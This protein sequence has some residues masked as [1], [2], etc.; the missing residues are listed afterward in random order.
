MR[1]SSGTFE[2]RDREQ[3]RPELRERTVPASVPDELRYLR[4]LYEDLVTVQGFAGATFGPPPDEATYEEARELAWLAH[5]LRAGGYEATM[6]SAK[7]R[8][9]PESLAAFKR[10]GSDIEV[11]ETLCARFF[12]RELPVAQQSVKLPL[13]TVKQAIRVTGP[14][15]LWDVELAPALRDSVAVHFNLTPLEET[16]ER[17]VA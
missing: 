10:S 12:G 2:I 5:A 6:H 17:H 13:M 15:P 16:A 1:R 7:M 4:R 14:D 11:R 9:G 3:Q 8:C